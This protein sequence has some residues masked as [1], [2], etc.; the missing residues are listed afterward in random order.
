MADLHLKKGKIVFIDGVR[1]G[2]VVIDKGTIVEITSEYKGPADR[3]IECQDKVIFP[4]VIDAHVHMRVPGSE[5]KED[6]TTG[7][8]AAI[9]GGVT[10]FLDMPNNIPPI[11][12]K[13]MLNEKR[14][15]IDGNSFA[16]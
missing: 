10:S 9:S 15:L 2:D 7:S 6:F 11:I 1:E 12:S 5:Y 14:S 8:M 13:K 16:N 4:G 3:V